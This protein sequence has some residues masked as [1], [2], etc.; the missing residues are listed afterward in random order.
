MLDKTGVPTQEQVRSRFP[1]PIALLRPKAILEC[2][3]DIPCNPC[4]TSCPFQAIDIGEN[5]NVQPQLNVHLCTGCGLCVPS[6]PGL[7]III[8]EIKGDKAWF[9][10]PYEVLPL[11]KNQEIWDGVD[12]N[13]DVI[14][15]AHIK[16]V[17]TNKHNDHTAVVTV[18]VP[19]DK[20]Y[21]FVTIRGRHE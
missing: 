16:A 19:L 3:E 21:D 6:C 17:L 4:E 5:I 13:G 15:D 9:K 2:Y 14:C 20:M 8:A 12:R 11:P 10:I 18:A 7:A 1:D